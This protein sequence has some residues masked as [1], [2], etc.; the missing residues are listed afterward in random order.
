MSK[1]AMREVQVQGDIG[2]W[3]Y[4]STKA[5]HDY[6]SK[7]HHPPFPQKLGGG[8]GDD[9]SSVLESRRTELTLSVVF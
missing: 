2:L 3:E 5:F 9:L 6:K 7:K 8:A 4:L 1:L